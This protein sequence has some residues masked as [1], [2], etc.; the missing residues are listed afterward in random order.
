[1]TECEDI[2]NKI[3]GVYTIYP[4]GSERAV[5]VY[6]IMRQTKKWTVSNWLNLGI[7]NCYTYVNYLVIFQYNL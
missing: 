7:E 4:G 6:C 1:M 3:D 2:P 5:L